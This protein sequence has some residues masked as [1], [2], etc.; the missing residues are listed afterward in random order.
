MKETLEKLW[1][2]YLSDKCS[3]QDTDE[4]RELAQ[5][6]ISLHKDIK[7][8]LPEEQKE[9]VERYADAICHMESA[10]TKKAFFKG[11][12]FAVSFLWETRG[13]GK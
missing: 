5:K 12:E 3:S 10:F 7:A 11:C 6:V 9:A 2:E 13:A 4:E 1:Y 8:M